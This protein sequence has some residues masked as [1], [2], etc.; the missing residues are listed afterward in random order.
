MRAS[1]LLTILTTLQARGR[2]TAQALAEECEVSLR[3][4]YRDVDALSAAGI[5]VYAERGPEGGY[6]LIDG[7][8]L[9][10][11]GLS[12]KEAATLF[13]AG[14]SGP[15]ADLG[16]GTVMAAAETKL[17]A[18]LPQG[19]RAEAER[20]RARFHLDAP[21]WFAEGEQPAHL[22][23]IAE[24]VWRQNRIEIRYRS[25]KA[26]KQRRVEPLG[27]V[28]KGGAWYLVGR[29]ETSIRTYRIARILNF[30]DL[31]ETFER[32]EAFDLPAYWKASTD[33]LEA[34]VHPDRATLR[35]SPRGAKMLAALSQ[36]FVRA[37]IDYGAEVDAAGWRIATLPV[38]PLDHAVVDLLR[39]GAEAEVLEPPALREKMAETIAAMAKLYR[40]DPEPAH[41]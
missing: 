5:P 29:V 7:Y 38:G 9:R 4:I 26:E 36:P 24:A 21:A 33:R 15:A 17:V 8:R 32:P 39:L 22:Q 35:L 18:A 23:A 30:A 14:L 20:I 2:A 27:I 40:R 37:R 28:L 1:R 19:L 41:P 34:E 31:G 10:L 13:L 16:L 25:W 12:S 11:N 6:R 3:T